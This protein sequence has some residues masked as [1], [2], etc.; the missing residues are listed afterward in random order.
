MTSCPYGLKILCFYWNL[1]GILGKW[2]G[3]PET[4]VMCHQLLPHVGWG[5]ILA[6]DV[7]TVD[8]PFSVGCE[9]WVN[10]TQ[11]HKLFHQCQ[12]MWGVFI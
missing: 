6:L 4:Q 3:F 11:L 1:G 10:S 12:W 8:F 9:V 7:R 5:S 2:E